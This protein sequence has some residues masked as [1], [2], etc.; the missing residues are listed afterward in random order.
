[1]QEA[2]QYATAVVITHIV[3][4]SHGKVYTAGEGASRPAARLSRAADGARRTDRPQQGAGLQEG[5]SP[6]SP[7]FI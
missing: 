4:A 3:T 5:L 6:G 1:M 7:G 2:V